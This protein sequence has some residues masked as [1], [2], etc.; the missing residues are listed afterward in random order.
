[1]HGI[2]CGNKK[3]IGGATV[4][5]HRE[6]NSEYYMNNNECKI[7]F[8][9]DNE[10]WR[11][12]LRFLELDIPDIDPN[13]GICNDALYIYDSEDVFTGAMV[14]KKTHMYYLKGAIPL[15]DLFNMTF[16]VKP[17]QAKRENCYQ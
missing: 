13:N 5:S 4:Y 7:T 15:W 6:E 10:G 3:Y 14:S 17:V 9:A 11:I 16:T 2:D 12:M 8:K 1:M